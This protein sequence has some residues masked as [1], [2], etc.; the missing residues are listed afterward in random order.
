MEELGDILKRLDTPSVSGDSQG[1]VEPGP[2]EQA[3][4]CPICGGRGWFTADVAVGHPDFGKAVTCECQEQ[5]LERERSERLLRYSN[6]G[7]LTRFTFEALDLQGQSEE[8]DTQRLF[9]DAYEA[10][11]QYSERPQGWLVFLGP[12]GSGKTHLAAAIG[13]RCIERGHV[14][15]FSHVP[16][17]L[18]H[19]RAAFGPTSDVAYSEL[20]DQVRSAPLLILDGLGAHS[21]TPW[22]EEKLRQII[23][24]RYNA[25][26]PTVVTTALPLDEL[27][28]SIRT[29]LQTPGLSRVIE[30]RSRVPERSDSLGQIPTQMLQS[31]TFES[32]DARGNNPNDAQRRSL[33]YAYKLAKTYAA[34]PHGWLTLFGDTGVGKTHM[35]VAIAEERLKTGNPVFF[36]MVSDLL[37]HLRATFEPNSGVTY[38]QRFEQIKNTPLLILDDLGRERSSPWADEKLHQIIV[39][40]HNTRL[41]TV[42]TTMIDFTRPEEQGPIGSRIQ[43]SSAG[44]LIRLD[45]PDYRNKQR[46]PKRARRTGSKAGARR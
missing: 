35:A 15:F 24:D 42:I 41:P 13:N 43:D 36:I 18:D 1:A 3:E 6:L 7:A 21:T 38:D 9:R 22:A 33:E 14:V 20:F 19:L 34:D 40:R 29:R 17:L 10:S 28:P 5:R 32:F 12:H 31:M 27:D 37:D 26:S 2:E 30:L 11:E 25:E 46:S 45:A 8:P 23:N 39:H 44:E 4:P 16:D